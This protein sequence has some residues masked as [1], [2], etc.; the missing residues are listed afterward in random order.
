MEK[1]YSNSRK[2]ES[3]V[4]LRSSGGLNNELDIHGLTWEDRAVLEVIAYDRS[5]GNLIVSNCNGLKWQTTLKAFQ[6]CSEEG[7]PV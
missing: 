1:A 4:K 2:I 3:F 5:A 6:C 7:N